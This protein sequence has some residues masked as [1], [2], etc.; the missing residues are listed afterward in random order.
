MAGRLFVSK[1][2]TR[3]ML[4][5]G[6]GFAAGV[7][8]RP[9]SPLMVN[10]HNHHSYLLLDAATWKD[11]EAEAVKLGGHLATIRNRAEE[12]WV[13]KTFGNYD[14]RQRLLWIGLSDTEKKFH[15]SWSSGESVSFT[16]WAP[17]EPNNV[18]NGEDF[19]AV[20]YPNHDQA[21]KW[22]DW[23]DRLT[24]PIGL[25]MNG[26]VEII[27]PETANAGT[28]TSQ[29]NQLEVVEINPTLI[30]TNDSGSIKLQWP[31]AATNYVLEATTNLSQPFAMFGYSETTNFEAEAFTVT[32]TNSEPQMFFRLYK[33]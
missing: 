27:P 18:G 10:P 33:P 28:A 25:P 31:V 8:A 14:G 9:A 5:A 21:N 13:F 3:L 29:A 2:I 23:D 16:D 4:A 32:I 24:D 17:G 22:N 19:V 15:F 6:L 11:S 20:Y 7:H 1:T 26:V 30:I 12:D